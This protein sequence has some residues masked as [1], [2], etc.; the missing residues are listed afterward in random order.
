MSN[1]DYD[2]YKDYYTSPEGIDE[3][4]RRSERLS[5]RHRERST[6]QAPHLTDEDRKWWRWRIGEN[7]RGKRKKR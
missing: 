2:P 3:R 5:R 6:W 1:N 4:Q 7:Q